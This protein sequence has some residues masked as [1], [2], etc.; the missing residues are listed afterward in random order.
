MDF[1]CRRASRVTRRVCEP[2]SFNP[3]E[4]HPHGSQSGPDEFREAQSGLPHE[5]L[6][7][8]LH[9]F[10]GGVRESAVGPDVSLED[11]PKRMI[12]G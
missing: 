6:L 10:A 12:E 3:R 2:V 7:G 4:V 8:D 5:F 1:G 11:I 9:A